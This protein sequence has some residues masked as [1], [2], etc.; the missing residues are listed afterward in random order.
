MSKVVATSIFHTAVVERSWKNYITSGIVHAVIIAV[1]F[2]ITIPAVRVMRAP[3]TDHVTLV[4]PVL[5]KYHPKIVA[6]PFPHVA[7]LVMPTL[8]KPVVKSIPAPV[9]PPPPPVVA[10]TVTPPPAPKIAPQP[11]IVA[12]VKPALPPP[13]KPVVKTGA[14]QETQVAKANVAPKQVVVGGFGDPRGAH[15]S[16]TPKPSPVLM[17]K[18]GSFDSPAGAGQTGGG[19]RMDIGSVKQ[20]GFGSVAAEAS[21]KGKAAL[22]VRAAG[23]GDGGTGGTSAGHGAATVRSS[24]FGE[25]VAAAPQRKDLPAA[26][27]AFTPVE[28]LFKPKPSYSAEARGLGL[29]GQVQLEVIFQASGAVRVVRVIKGLGHG[30]DE[31][32]QQAATQVRF[33]PAT[34]SGAPVD[35]NATISITFE[36]T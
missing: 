10:K 24:G 22:A 33:K 23:F 7:K 6:P 19:G 3:E 5:P 18:V 9:I 35:T 29:V 25:T 2:L 31:A 28:I 30:L 16:D 14:F 13:P 8:P 32:A 26:A 36:L 27:P 21:G 34:R 15:E 1:A 17:A 20:S 12:E 11:Q 4:A